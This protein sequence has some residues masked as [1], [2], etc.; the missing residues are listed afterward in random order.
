[1]LLLWS[2]SINACKT[3][4]QCRR[5]LAD[6][7][8]DGPWEEFGISRNVVWPELEWPAISPDFNPI[9]HVWDVF[10]SS[11]APQRLAPRSIDELKR[12]LVQDWV[13]LPQA[14]ISTLVN[15]IKHGE[16]EFM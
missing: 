9:G 15:S 11:V 13:R 4:L 1:M 3:P 14:L 12:F 2:C 6:K 10:G 7:A 5:P 16:A 8:V